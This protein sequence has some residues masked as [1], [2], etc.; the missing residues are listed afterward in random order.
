MGRVGWGGRGAVGSGP[1]LER[2]G[3]PPLCPAAPAFGC[4]AVGW[5]DVSVGP[6]VVLGPAVGSD[7]LSVGELGQSVE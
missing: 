2:Q 1:G 3:G 7:L 5:A 4:G 6:I